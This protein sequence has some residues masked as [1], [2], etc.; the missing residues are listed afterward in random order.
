M[1]RIAVAHLVRKRNGTEPLRR[2]LYS[3]RKW[4]PG[5]EHDLIFI[6]K[7]FRNN[8][9]TEPYRELFDSIPHK[10]LDV[11]DKGYDITSY[12][13][14]AELLDH[15]Y[16]C[17]LNSF[18]T[19]LQEA[20]LEKL[21]RVVSRNGVGLAGATGSYQSLRPAPFSYYLS[22]S[23]QIKH[24]GPIKDILMSLPFSHYL[25][26][27]RRKL[28]IG[29]GFH[30]FP[31]YH[32]RTNGFILSRDIMRHAVQKMVLTKMDAYRFESGRRS[33]TRQV[34]E[35]GLDAVVVG[36]DGQAYNKEE[37]YLSDTFW[38][39]QQQ[40]LLVADNQT[41]HYDKGSSELRKVLASLAWGDWARFD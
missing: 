18:S 32:I 17:F 4:D 1:K 8:L 24:R 27:L 9:E 11:P 30:E 5:I 22:V 28:L 38:Q 19:I 31:N 25:N 15:E 10:V 37:W 40:N 26:L 7:G 21:F 14:A 6:F 29:P 13:L 39:T 16:F 2:F 23:R 36:A 41:R 35:T 33:V 20:W 34:I 3:Y 12:W